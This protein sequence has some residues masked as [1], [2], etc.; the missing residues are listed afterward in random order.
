MRSAIKYACTVPRVLR[1]FD[2][3]VTALARPR[4]NCTVIYRP[5]LSS[6]RALK[7]YKTVNV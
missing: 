1:D 3:R 2:L 4:S 7:T 5:V 6:E